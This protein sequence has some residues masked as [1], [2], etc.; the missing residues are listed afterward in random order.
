VAGPKEQKLVKLYGAKYIEAYREIIESLYNLEESDKRNIDFKQRR[1]LGK[2]GNR[3]RNLE[4][5]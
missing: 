4:K 3:K 5:K 2:N 1:N